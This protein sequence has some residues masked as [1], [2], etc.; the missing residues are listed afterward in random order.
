[1][2][3]YGYDAWGKVTYTRTL[4][5]ANEKLVELYPFRYRGYVWDEETGWYYLRSRYYASSWGRFVNADAIISDMYVLFSANTVCYGVNNPI[6]FKDLSGMEPEIVYPD[7]KFVRL[8]KW[9]AL[10]LEGANL[11]HSATFLERAL[12]VNPTSVHYTS[13]SNPKLI[14]DIKAR[15]DFQK[16]FEELVGIMA[17][18]KETVSSSFEFT[19]NDMDLY[20]SLKR[21]QITVKPVLSGDDID[22]YEV[23]IF[24]V[25]DFAH[26]EFKENG[27]RIDNVVTLANNLAAEALEK[28]EISQYNIGISFKIRADEE[29]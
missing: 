15:A 22:N 2:V 5:S 6:R 29:L 4:T 16:K 13:S 18:T 10:L 23:S 12:R 26:V 7:V 28:G 14:S 3:E 19:S 8:F 9:V 20:G 21:V 24:D 17:E 1:M 25:Y 27:G 11:T